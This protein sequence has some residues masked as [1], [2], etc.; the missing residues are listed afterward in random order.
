MGTAQLQ[1][2]ASGENGERERLLVNFF[3]DLEAKANIEQGGL[4]Q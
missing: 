3:F 1:T 4:S 2:P